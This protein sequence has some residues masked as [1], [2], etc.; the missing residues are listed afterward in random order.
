MNVEE[1]KDKQKKN[2]V[3]YSDTRNNNLGYR[4]RIPIEFDSKNKKTALK[5]RIQIADTARQPRESPVLKKEIQ[6]K[7]RILNIVPHDP[8]DLEALPGPVIKHEKKHKTMVDVK[9][10]HLRKAKTWNKGTKTSLP[11]VK[12]QSPKDKS[13][14]K[15]IRT[16]EF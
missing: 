14:Q 8:E 7:P 5:T 9:A 1:A 2:S 16:I 3:R 13:P 4:I 11:E 12:Q 15:S 10:A 6:T